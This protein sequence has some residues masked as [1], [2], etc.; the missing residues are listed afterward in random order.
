MQYSEQSWNHDSGKN[1]YL[2]NLTLQNTDISSLVG[3]L[4]LKT[5]N[6]STFG[7]ITI[8][9]NTYKVLTHTKNVTNKHIEPN[10][11]FNR[12]IQTYLGNN[13]MHSLLKNNRLFTKYSNSIFSR[14]IIKIKISPIGNK[15]F[16][17]EKSTIKLSSPISNSVTGPTR[18][19]PGYNK[20]LF[21]YHEFNNILDY[22]NSIDGSKYKV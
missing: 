2:F 3:N 5:I 13:R 11:I 19:V 21:P 6:T 20:L 22:S 15:G 16:S 4:D 18:A 1:L 8:P 17:Y 7:T 9:S 10:S 12:I 14:R